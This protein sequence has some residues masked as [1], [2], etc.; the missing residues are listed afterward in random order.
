MTHEIWALQPPSI[1]ILG[2]S[3]LGAFLSECL[4]GVHVIGARPGGSLKLGESSPSPFSPVLPAM[5][6]SPS[7]VDIY[8]LIFLFVTHS[9]KPRHSPNKE[10]VGTSVGS[11]FPAANRLFWFPGLLCPQQDFCWVGVGQAW[12]CGTA[13]RHCVLAASF[14][15]WKWAA[16]AGVERRRDVW[17]QEKV[18]GFSGSQMLVCGVWGKAAMLSWGE[19]REDQTKRI[20]RPPPLPPLLFAIWGPA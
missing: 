11:M 13:R 12:E 10:H 14:G 9:R 16:A 8:F 18:L 4:W 17:F 7:S 15:V 6:L 1:S 20:L 3:P 2:F 19:E 5:I